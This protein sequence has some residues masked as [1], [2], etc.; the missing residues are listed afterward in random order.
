MSKSKKQQFMKAVPVAMAGT[1]M[2]RHLCNTRFLRSSLILE[3]VN[4]D[5][6]D[7]VFSLLN[8]KTGRYEKITSNGVLKVVAKNDIVVTMYIPGEEKIV[9]MYKS[10]GLYPPRAIISAAKRA[11]TRF[12]QLESE[13]MRK[14]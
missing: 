1:V 13:K 10:Q 11:R 7:E 2:S 6:G 4:Y 9:A 12:N 5:I 8:S 14:E 3:A